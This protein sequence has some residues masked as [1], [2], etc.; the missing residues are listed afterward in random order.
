M[1]QAR[2]GVQ[3]A[4]EINGI[5][6]EQYEEKINRWKANLDY[7]PFIQTFNTKIGNR[8]KELR[9]AK[10]WSVKQLAKKASLPVDG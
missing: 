10:G 5:T 4:L 2:A 6:N 9:R 3:T 7:F 1:N 8:I